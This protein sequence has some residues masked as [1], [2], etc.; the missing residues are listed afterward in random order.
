MDSLSPHLSPANHLP[1]TDA[2]RV[3]SDDPIGVDVAAS[4]ASVQSD[5][6]CEAVSSASHTSTGCDTSRR[7]SL[8]DALN[9]GELELLDDDVG[10]QNCVRLHIICESVHVLCANM[11][12]T[13]SH[14][15]LSHTGSPS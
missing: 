12:H 6:S 2:V 7:Q 9:D 5:A 10:K 13:S 14:R 15:V 3:Q 11:P 8:A 4:P 1:V